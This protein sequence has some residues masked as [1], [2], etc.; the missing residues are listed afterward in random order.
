MG[1]IW[2][3]RWEELGAELKRAARLRCGGLGVDMRKAGG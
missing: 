3:V 2:E 1:G